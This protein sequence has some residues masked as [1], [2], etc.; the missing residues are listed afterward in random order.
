MQIGQGRSDALRALGRPHQRPRGPHLRQRHGAGRRVRHPDRPGAAR[1]V[2]RDPGQAPPAGRGEGAAGAGEDHHPA[3]L[4]HPALPLHRGHGARRRSASWTASADD[5]ARR[6]PPS[7]TASRSARGCSAI[8]DPRHPDLWSRDDSG[9]LLALAAVGAIWRWPPASPSG[10]TGRACSSLLVEAAAGRRP[11]PRSASAA[12]S[13][14]LGAL[15]VPPFTAGLRRGVRGMAARAVGRAGRA[16]RW[17]ALRLYGG[18]DRRRRASDTFT[19]VADGRRPRPDRQLPALRSCSGRRRPADAVPRRPGAAPRADRPLRQPR[20]R[21]GPDDARQPDRR[22]RSATSCR[23]SPLAV[24]VPRDDELSPAGHR[25]RRRPRSTTTPARGAGHRRAAPP[26]SRASAAR[27]S[28]SRSRPTTGVVAVV[29]GLLP[30]RLRPAPAARLEARLEAVWHARSQPTAVQLDTAL[31]FTALPR[32]RH[33]RRATPAGPRDARRRRPGH[34][35]ARLPRRRASPPARRRRPRRRQLRLLRDRITRVVGEVRRS[36]QTP[37]HRGR[38]PATASAP[39]SAAWPATSAT[40]PASRSGSRVDER[41]TR[42]RTEVEAELLRIAQEAMTN[43]VRHSG[44]V[45]DRRRCRVARPAR[46]DRRHATT[47]RARPRAL[48]LPR[49][50]D[51]A[52]ARPP[53]RRRPRDRATASPTAPSSRSGSVR[54]RAPPRP[55]SDAPATG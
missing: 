34:R 19:W 2:Q 7:T 22:D 49:P 3:D 14:V 36:V 6:S 39:P 8:A 9:S 16:A 42:L 29:A 32:R 11:S 24:H 45:L 1:A 31:L 40:A 28:R 51:H 12:R 10:S 17:S 54:P 52:R 38:A 20:L 55:R 13:L 44:A 37:A 25:A 21:P 5:H 43:A 27:R 30:P 15:A 41:T 35:L 26:R 46:R 50:R 4:L 33:H 48:R 23:C 53:G 47:A 18:L